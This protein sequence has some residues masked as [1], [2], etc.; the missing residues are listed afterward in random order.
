MKLVIWLFLSQTPQKYIFRWLNEK[1]EK[2]II[3]L[4]KTHRNFVWNR[5][6]AIFEYK[7][8][9]KRVS[10][11][12]NPIATF[13]GWIITYLP[14]NRKR[15]RKWRFGVIARKWQN[16][17]CGE[18]NDSNDLRVYMQLFLEFNSNLLYFCGRRT[19]VYS[20]LF[21]FL[22]GQSHQTISLLDTSTNLLWNHR[23]RGGSITHEQHEK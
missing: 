12:E 22:A 1:I 11:K 4:K 14:E 18:Y 16:S 6:W 2:K 5:Y 23:Q 21:D 7:I 15:T 19:G 3:I 20:N 13:H 9:I 8:E 17:K 10:I